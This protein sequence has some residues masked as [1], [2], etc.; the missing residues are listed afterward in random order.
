[1]KKFIA[2]CDPATGV[3]YLWE[4]KVWELAGEA[5]RNF[6]TV[7][8][9]LRDDLIVVTEY[10]ADYSIEQGSYQMYTPAGK[11]LTEKFKPETYYDVLLQTEALVEDTDGEPIRKYSF[12]TEK[13]SKYPL[14]RCMGIFEE[15]KVPTNLKTV[16]E[17]VREVLG[18][19]NM[20]E[21]HKYRK[22]IKS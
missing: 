8:D 1:M 3:T 6:I 4:Q 14:A 19:P 11:M 10:H 13:T 9:S 20:E 17:K 12:V 15:T 2:G 21:F 16:L 18:M 22:P 7:V 5:L